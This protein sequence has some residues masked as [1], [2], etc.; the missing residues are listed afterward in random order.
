MTD[1]P[2]V[3]CPSN[4]RFDYL[5]ETPAFIKKLPLVTSIQHFIARAALHEWM[6]T[7]DPHSTDASCLPSRFG[8]CVQIMARTIMT[9][10]QAELAYLTEMRVLELCRD[11]E[12]VLLQ[13]QAKRAG[14]SDYPP[15]MAGIPAWLRTHVLQADDAAKPIGD[16]TN[17]RS[18]GTIRPFEQHM[19]DELLD[20]VPTAD[21]L[22][23]PAGMEKKIIIPNAK[24]AGD[25][26]RDDIRV[27]PYININSIFALTLDT[28]SIAWLERIQRTKLAKTDLSDR[29]VVH[30]SAT[31]EARNEAR[32][33]A[34]YDLA[35]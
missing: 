21:L 25:E 20:R 5:L 22:I 28:W 9:G 4:P 18:P 11:L 24:R 12:L 10:P 30:C 8:N 32:N 26:I 29:W 3:D 13:N 19:L 34:I 35:V 27:I 1:I 15:K 6:G 23:V 14:S 2:T 16:G 31:L 17:A 33:G 7:G